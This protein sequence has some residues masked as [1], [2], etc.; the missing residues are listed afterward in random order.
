MSDIETINFVFQTN[1]AQGLEREV[2]EDVGANATEEFVDESEY[3]KCEKDAAGACDSSV[4]QRSGGERAASARG[5][6]HV[7][8]PRRPSPSGYQA[9]MIP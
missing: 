2:I 9:L 8:G 5:R 3:G 6:G 7:G 1:R 4:S